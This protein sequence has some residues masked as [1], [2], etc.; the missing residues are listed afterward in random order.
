MF[1]LI[2]I[3]APLIYRSLVSRA[4]Q[5]KDP[6]DRVS[7][8]KVPRGSRDFKAF[9]NSG[10]SRVASKVDRNKAGSK[11]VAVLRLVGKE[12]PE[13]SSV[14]HCRHDLISFAVAMDEITLACALWR[15][16]RPVTQVKTNITL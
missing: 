13:T 3:A 4:F 2:V 1:L 9:H 14:L 5:G 11:S 12:V 10:N 8:D 6:K 16:R 15:M 7:K